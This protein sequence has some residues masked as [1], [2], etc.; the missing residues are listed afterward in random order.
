MKEYRAVIEGNK[1][2]MPHITQ[3]QYLLVISKILTSKILIT[4]AIIRVNVPI[5]KG[6]L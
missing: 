3:Q 4:T 2:T 6:V 1:T 5:S